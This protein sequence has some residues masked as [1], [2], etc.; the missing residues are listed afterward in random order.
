MAEQGIE[1]FVGR[2]LMIMA[3]AP[4][5]GLILKQAGFLWGIEVGIFIFIILVF[6]Q[7]LLPGDL[8]HPASLSAWR[9]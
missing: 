9:V 5:L 2:Q 1:N 6:I 3:A 4:L 8:I 7:C